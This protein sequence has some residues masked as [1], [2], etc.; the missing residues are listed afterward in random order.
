LDKVGILPTEKTKP[1]TDLDSQNIWIYGHPG[2]GKTT[3]AAQFEK[4]IFLA[5]EDG[6]K[7]HSIY[8]VDVK[9]WATFAKV[10]KALKEE[11][12]D[13][14]TVVIDTIDNLYSF[15]S[16]AVCEKLGIQHESDLGFGKGWKLVRGQFM[17]ALIATSFLPMGMVVIGH[18]EQTEVET[19]TRK[20]T[21]T[22]PSLP[23]KVWTEVAKMMDIIMLAES[24]QT[25][26]GEVR[27]LRTKP[28]ENWVAKDRT[29]VAR[30]KPLP[31]TLPLDFE[32]FK[33]AYEGDVE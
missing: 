7:S 1:I 21:K 6:H 15:C 17:K 25:K 20:I 8:K 19:R 23:E 5:T 13:F 27:V 26:D 24:I 14:K 33:K 30:K 4:P 12:H 2:I 32:Q 31:D 3:F 16:H 9:D 18:T 10:I 22:V 29:A 28:A 11:K